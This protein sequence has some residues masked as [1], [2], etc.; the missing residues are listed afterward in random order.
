MISKRELDLLFEISK[1]LKKYGE[2]TFNNLVNNLKDES[3]VSSIEVLAKSAPNIKTP[4]RKT[5]ARIDYSKNL[6]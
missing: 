2:E 5:K 4:T 6:S 3:F 1:L